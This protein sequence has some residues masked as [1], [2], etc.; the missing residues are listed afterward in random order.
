MSMFP[1][2]NIQHL[3]HSTS[4][5][6]PL[7][8][9]TT[10]E[11]KRKR[12]ETFRLEAWWLME[13]TFE[14]EVQRIWESAS[15]DLIQ[16]LEYLKSEL[17]K[18]A[19]RIGRLRNWKNK[20]LTSKLAAVMEVE[21]TYDNL[22]ELIDTKLQLNFEIDKDES[23][24]E[25]R[26]RVNWVRLGDR[27]TTFFHSK[28]WQNCIH[29]LQDP[30]GRATEDQQEMAEIVKNYFQSLF[31]AE[32]MGHFEHILTG[33]D[34]C[35]SEEDNRCLVRPFIK[36][37]IWEALTNM[38]A[39]KAP[40]E[41]GLPAIFFQ[42][43]WHIFGNEVSSFCIQQ[44]NGGME[45]TRLNT[46]HIVL[47]LKKV[48]QTNLSHFRPINLCNVIYKIMAKAIANSFRG[49][50]EKC[51]DKAQ[52]AFVPGRLIS[53][54]AL[55]TYEL[56]NTLKK[57]RIRRKGL[58]AVK[59]D[60]SKAYDRVEWSFLK[61]MMGK[62]GFDPRWVNL[63]MMC[64][65]TV[66]YAIV[67]N[68]HIGNI[69]YPSRGLRQGD[70]LS[71]F[72]FLI[73]GE[74]SRRGPQISYLLFADDCILFG[75]AT[76]RGANILKRVLR[77]Y[78]ICSRQQVNF[79]KSTIFFSS[80]T[81]TEGKDLVTRLLGV[82]SSNDLERYLG[83]P[84]MVGR[85]KKE[86]FQNLKD[87][88][89]QRI[90]NWSIRHL[91]QGGK[92]VFIKAILQAIPTYIMACFV[93][94]KTL[95]S[96]LESIIARFWWQKGHGQRG[97]H[98]CTWR[99]LCISK[100]KGGLGFRSLDQFNIALLAK[101]GWRFINYPDSLLAQV[102]KAKYYPN[103]NFL[104]AQLGNLPSLTWRSIWAGK[105]LL[106]DGLCWRIG[107]G[108][109]VSIWNDCWIPGVDTN[110]IGNRANNSELESVSGLIDSTTRLWKRDYLPRTHSAEDPP[111][112]L[113]V[114]EHDDFQVWRG[115]HSGEFTVRSAYQLL[116]KVT[117]DPNELLLQTKSKKFYRKL[118][119]LQL[120]SKVRIT[121]WRFTWNFIP[122]LRNLKTRRVVHDSVCPRCRNAEK[123]SNH[124]LKKCPT[125]KE[126]WQN[127]SLSWVLNS[128]ITELWSWFTWVFERE[129]SNE[130]QTICCAA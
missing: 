47:I 7:L 121:I 71:P 10:K 34:R 61:V 58:M 75:E 128:N 20:Y 48:H 108:D 31:K 5:H 12:W 97:I 60:M 91:S 30:D 52:S 115:E 103:S 81:S 16:K 89:R 8:I 74:A 94:P 32:E 112:S 100:E 122:T 88:F 68:R 41:D 23:Y 72:L 39:T 86:A 76:E 62:M 92:E 28:Q 95:C 116:Q 85:R 63:I 40:G 114:V 17:G 109:Q 124:V 2:T 70:P 120:P 33:V 127:L 45:V 19:L 26:A 59:L 56:L 6:C 50:L 119:N 24:W 46:T 37:E 130:C 67:L 125:S 129:S 43:L 55:I 87:R 44:L 73:Y 29:K 105:K 13:E 96:E 117:T 42:K 123:D 107:K 22:A 77:E 14:T 64:I 11:E 51:I 9:T 118:W 65:S 99:E 104:Q 106:K 27:N 53:D 80:N 110:E 111:S 102:L 101:Q 98:W 4:N 126:L 83:L 1:E 78:R 25:Q 84:N 79:D 54:N 15:G 35:I 3:V 90:D 49:V 21:R 69:F 113:A 18:W 57:K 93:L 66:S 82:R 38:G 36:E